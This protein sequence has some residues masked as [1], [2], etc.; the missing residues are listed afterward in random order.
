[1]FVQ[2]RK[3]KEAADTST[4]CKES[5]SNHGEDMTSK[6]CGARRDKLTM[7]VKVKMM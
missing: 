5:S 7:E 4:N 6:S 3:K 2:E 1:M